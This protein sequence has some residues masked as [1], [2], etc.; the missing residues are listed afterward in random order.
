MKLYLFIFLLK[1]AAE[2][3]LQSN[4]VVQDY[5]ELIMVDDQEDLFHH[6]YKPITDEDMLVEYMKFQLADDAIKS[7]Y[8]PSTYS[9]NDYDLP[10]WDDFVTL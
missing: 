10:N 6:T 7:N 1:A 2:G 4:T 3:V 8:I 5:I 9:P